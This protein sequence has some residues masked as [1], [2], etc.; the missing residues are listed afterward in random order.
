MVSPPTQR[1]FDWRAND[2]QHTTMGII[3]WCA[4]LAG[5]WLSRDRDG[6]P[7]R[8]FIPGF[9]LA[10]L[11]VLTVWAV[12]WLKPHWIPRV[13]SMPFAERLR[14]SVGMWRAVRT[15]RSEHGSMAPCPCVP[16]LSGAM[17]RE[18][19]PTG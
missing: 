8:N 6:A 9:V 2:W 15:C 19:T 12:A 5:S 17:C 10:G 3:W 4:G 11:Y 7:K 16:K 14:A 13:K 18:C 1:L